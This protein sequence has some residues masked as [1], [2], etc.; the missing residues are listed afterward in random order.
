VA[1]DLEQS[2]IRIRTEYYGKYPEQC[3]ALD[4]TATNAAIVSRMIATSMK[5]DKTVCEFGGTDVWLSDIIYDLEEAISEA[6]R[7]L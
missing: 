7:A 4:A 5:D 2:L 1:S 3:G 6:K